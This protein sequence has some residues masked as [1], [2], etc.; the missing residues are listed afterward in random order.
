MALARAG[1]FIRVGRAPCLCVDEPSSR[2]S[3]RPA[4]AAPRPFSGARAGAAA[5]V[6]R[7]SSVGPASS[8]AAGRA[9]GAITA[10][11]ASTE[12]PAS[13]AAV[14]L[15]TAPIARITARQTVGGRA[16][17]SK[18]RALRR[19]KGRV[20]I[21]GAAASAGTAPA[22]RGATGPRPLTEGPTTRISVEGGG[23][24]E[25]ATPRPRVAGATQARPIACPFVIG[26]LRGRVGP[27]CGSVAGPLR[28][29]PRRGA[30][31][32]GRAR[33]EGIIPLR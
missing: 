27:G 26:A 28:V 21:V 7:G 2:P 30:L 9:S 11:G 10:G 3:L 5:R 31:V 22:F 18:R 29:A 6:R 33:L 1:R 13:P 8:G 17:R 4:L 14:G 20:S 25:G 19:R 12:A 24:R 16:S 32:S 23:V 15:S